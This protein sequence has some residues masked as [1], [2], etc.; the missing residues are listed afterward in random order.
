MMLD[1]LL[2]CVSATAGRSV[3]ALSLSLRAELARRWRAQIL[4]TGA[5]SAPKGDDASIANRM[6]AIDRGYLTV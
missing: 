1:R 3:S 6:S 5:V 4:L 2:R